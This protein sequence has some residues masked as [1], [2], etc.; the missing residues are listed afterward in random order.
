M[1][2]YWPSPF[3][4]KFLGLVLLHCFK[5]FEQLFRW[6]SNDKLRLVGGTRSVLLFG[7]RYR[8]HTKYVVPRVVFIVKQRWQS[9]WISCAHC[10]V[11]HRVWL[12]PERLWQC[13]ESHWQR[14]YRGRHIGLDI[15]LTNMLT[16]T[17][18]LVILGTSIHMIHA[19]RTIFA[20]P[21]LDTPGANIGLYTTP[22]LNGMICLLTS[23]TVLTFQLLGVLLEIT[24]SRQM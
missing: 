7:R 13:S 1:H 3:H 5:Q 22:P 19:I 11:V 17:L 21:P 12:L 2:F 4:D 20:S 24:K 23:G 6:W 9:Y 10:T 14:V 18:I 15:V 16:G 8:P